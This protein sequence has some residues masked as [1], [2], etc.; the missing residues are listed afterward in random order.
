MQYLEGLADWLP[1]QAGMFMWLKLGAGVKDADDIIDTLRE[2]KVGLVPGQYANS[3]G[4]I[5]VCLSFNGAFLSYRHEGRAQTC[6][7]GQ[8]QNHSRSSLSLPEGPSLM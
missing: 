7:T 2:E 1:P 3:A 8:S 4:T 5:A 6:L